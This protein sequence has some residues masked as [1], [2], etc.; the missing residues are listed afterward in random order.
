[1]ALTQSDHAGADTPPPP[2]DGSRASHRRLDIQG[3]RA[4]AVLLV[5]TYH[6]GLPIPGGFV[7]VDVFFVISGFLITRGLLRERAERGQVDLRRFW[8][9]RARRLLPAAFAFI[10]LLLIAAQ[11]GFPGEIRSLRGI[12]AAAVG[13]VTNWYLIFSHVPYFETLGHPRLL[14]HLWS[15]AVEEQFYL[16]WPPLLLLGLRV[17]RPSLVEIGRA[18]V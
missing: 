15:L 16:L 13:Y 9:R 5:V 4:I 17:A 7:G 2:E 3:L 12:A 18:H 10:L 11:V 1:M 6:A 8:V 14:H